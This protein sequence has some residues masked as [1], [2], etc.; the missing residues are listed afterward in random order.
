M[1]ILRTL[2]LCGI[3][4]SCPLSAQETAQQHPL[5]TTEA[6]ARVHSFSTEFGSGWEASNLVL[7]KDAFAADGKPLENKVWSSA[8][9][10]P[11]PH[12]ILFAFDE[13]QSFETFV[14]DNWLEDEESHPGISA[15]GIEL[16]IGDKPD[17]LTKAA[18]FELA[19]NETG[20][21]VRIEP[22]TGQYL[23]L[24]ITSNWGHPWYTELGYTRALSAEKPA[25]DI[26]SRL[27]ADGRADLYGLYF[28]FG[29]ARLRAESK[30]ILEEI[31]A[32][33]R[34]EPSRQY[35]VEGHTDSVGDPDYNRRLSLERAQAVVA[36]L[37]HMGVAPDRFEAQ[38]FGAD[39]PVADNTTD[40]G[41]AKNRR[42]T[43]RVLAS[44]ASSE[45]NQTP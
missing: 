4:F 43:L 44:P 33:Y 36:A 25:D 14:F 9:N 1:K 21:S 26:A 2:A 12:W 23:K 11:F 13:P 45:T 27:K 30:P 15:R 38:G 41:R 18:A 6:G 19:R 35:V 42:V 8:T 7:S 40:E 37:V 29:S 22:A 5:L 10:A 28:D 34:T 16:W 31:L 17:S 3:L 20:Q 39:S 32:L 24:V